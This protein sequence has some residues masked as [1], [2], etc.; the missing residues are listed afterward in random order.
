MRQ[1]GEKQVGQHSTSKPRP[2]EKESQHFRELG[3]KQSSQGKSDFCYMQPE[4]EG[5][6]KRRQCGKF[7][8]GG[9][10][11]W[12]AQWSISKIGVCV[13]GGEVGAGNELSAALTPSSSSVENEEGPE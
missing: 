9:L 11:F 13:W 6:A 1:R 2:W 12:K 10:L 3:G 5:I 4:S 7:A 8:D